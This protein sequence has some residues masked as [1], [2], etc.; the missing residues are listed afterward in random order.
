MSMWSYF[1]VNTVIGFKFVIFQFWNLE[2]GMNHQG[3]MDFFILLNNFKLC[4]NLLTNC[5]FF[6]NLY[7]HGGSLV[8]HLLGTQKVRGSNPKLILN[9][10]EY[11]FLHLYSNTQRLC[12]SIHFS[13]SLKGF[14]Y[15]G[16]VAWI[17]TGELFK[18]RVFFGKLV[19]FSFRLI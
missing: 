14:L 6:N 7:K 18:I 10:N 15:P 19:Y 8:S 5:Y 13:F 9:K 12:G 11:L 1:L 16:L 2:W 4:H 17:Q 3:Q